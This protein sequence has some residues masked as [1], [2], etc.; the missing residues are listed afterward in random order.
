[1]WSYYGT[2][3]NL[4]G[5]YPAPQ[6]A[7]IIEPFAG[8]AKYSLK[9]WERDIILCDKYKV[10]TDI[11]KW[12]QQC[13]KKD[14]LGLPRPADGETVDS[15]DIC[16]QAKLLLG[17]IIHF[18][19]YSPGK[20]PTSHYTKHRPN[21]ID[22]SIRRIAN[23]VHKIK[24]WKVIHGDYRELKNDA[25]CWFI[26]P[27]YIVGGAKY[28]C[29]GKDIDYK[30]LSRWCLTRKGQI[31][32]CENDTASWLP[33]MPFARNKTH[34]GDRVESLY[35]QENLPGTVFYPTQGKLF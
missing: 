6:H 22:F 20:K 1:M 21:G 3:T 27:P 11:W 8:A 32:V 25:A 4:A 29:S 15:F 34:N 35:Y 2:K 13:S 31:I 14:I 28:Y 16:Y 7:L 5:R 9:Y 30:E 12:L 17:F 23:D 19:A 10:I 33:F 26:D 24:H 18:G